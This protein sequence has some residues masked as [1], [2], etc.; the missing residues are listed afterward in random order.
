MSEYFTLKSLEGL[1]EEFL[2]GVVKVKQNRLSVLDGINRLDDISRMSSDGHN[3]NEA[4]GEW[5]AEHNQW[6]DKS[7][8]KDIEIGRIGNLLENISF[9]I[10]KDKISTPEKRK[11]ASEIDR[12]NNLAEKTPKK[13]ILKRHGETVKNPALNTITMYDNHLEKAL[14]LFKDKAG[15][16]KHILS[17]LDDSLKSAFTQKNKDALLLSGYIIYYLKLDGYLVDPY[18]KRLKEAEQMLKGKK[19]DV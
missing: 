12:W 8:L 7:V 4:I 14:N 5:F 17:V 9:G 11:L 18:V 13:V 3:I 10:S 6:L 1:L 15:D 16:K 19:A 2:A